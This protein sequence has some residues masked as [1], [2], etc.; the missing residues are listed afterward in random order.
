MIKSENGQ[1]KVKGTFDIIETDFDCLLLGALTSIS[2]PN[3][4]KLA[5][6]LANDIDIIVK[7]DFDHD[8]AQNAMI[9]KCIEEMKK[10]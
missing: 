3:A 5:S 2:T 1:V 9:K 10:L 8:K 7:A 4:V 6:T